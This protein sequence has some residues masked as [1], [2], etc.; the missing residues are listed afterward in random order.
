MTK[1][2]YFAAAFTGTTR[3][4]G[5]DGPQRATVG[6]AQADC[7]ALRGWDFRLRIVDGNAEINLSYDDSGETAAVIDAEGGVWRASEEAQ[8]QIDLA[9]YPSDEAIRRCVEE[10]MCGC[11]AQ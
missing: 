1:A 8:Q 7:L 2:S 4:P 3:I 5:G 11:W 6:E 9:D 10:P